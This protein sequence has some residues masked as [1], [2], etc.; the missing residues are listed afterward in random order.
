[1]NR[2][3]AGCGQRTDEENRT[4]TGTVVCD[5]CWDEMDDDKL[6]QLTIEQAGSWDNVIRALEEDR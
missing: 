2:R 6:E 1:M 3:C 4:A 5:D